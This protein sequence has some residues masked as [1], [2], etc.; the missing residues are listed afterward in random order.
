M[1]QPGRV[2]PPPPSKKLVVNNKR[3]KL[4]DELRATLAKKGLRQ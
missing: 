2:P 1:D 4:M 3:A